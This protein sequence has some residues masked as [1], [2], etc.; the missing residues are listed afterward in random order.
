MKPVIG[1]LLSLIAQSIF[2]LGVFAPSDRA[3]PPLP[4]TECHTVV[5]IEDN[6]AVHQDDA[7]L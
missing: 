6:H 1:I 3:L 2:A 4:L 7:H 5:R